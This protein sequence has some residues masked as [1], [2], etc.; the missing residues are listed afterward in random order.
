LLI[1][2]IQKPWFLGALCLI[3]AVAAVAGWT[4]PQATVET[5]IE[6]IVYQDKVQVVEKLVTVKETG[7]KVIQ[8]V[9]TE[10]RKDG[11]QVKTEEAIQEGTQ[12]DSSASESDT[13]VEQ[14]TSIA[15]E[16]SKT[17]VSSLSRYSLAVSVSAGTLTLPG[18]KLASLEA[19]ARLGS[20]PIF[21]TFRPDIQV[22]NPISIPT[23][24][25]GLRY[26]W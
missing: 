5:T 15:K 16:T 13:T 14:T 21:L 26:E 23:L 10:T 6:K 9:T 2:L 1:S 8:R 19:G 3:L 4:R 7:T 12:R 11:T 17:S 25:I 20:L 24:N 18:T 22:L